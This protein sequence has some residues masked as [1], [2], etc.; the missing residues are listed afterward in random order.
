[1][2]YAPTEG[3][4]LKQLSDEL[5]KTYSEKYE[6]FDHTKHQEYDGESFEEMVSLFASDAFYRLHHVAQEYLRLKGEP[7]GTL[8]RRLINGASQEQVEAVGVFEKLNAEYVDLSVSMREAFAPSVESV[9]RDCGSEAG[10][11]FIDEFVPNCLYAASAKASLRNSKN[12]DDSCGALGGEPIFPDLTEEQKSIAKAFVSLRAAK[13]EAERSMMDSFAPTVL[14]IAE[15]SG[16]ESAIR[17]LYEV[18]PDCA[19]RMMEISRLY[20]LEEGS[21]TAKSPNK[22]RVKSV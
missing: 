10:I 14:D 6:E 21:E 9:V 7:E 16:A 4:S 1:M 5:V 18:V 15:K 19:A 20:G 13:F 12:A 3:L 2:P 8:A 17:Y 11:R 22:P